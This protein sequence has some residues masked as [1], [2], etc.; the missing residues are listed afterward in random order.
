MISKATTP[1]ETPTATPGP[2]RRDSINAL[3]SASGIQ[4]RESSTPVSHQSI[5]LPLISKYFIADLAQSTPRRPYGPRVNST[6]I[7]SS[8]P[9][10][11]HDSISADR[12]ASYAHPGVSSAAN[13]VSSYQDDPEGFAGLEMGVEAD[14][15]LHDPEKGDRVSSVMPSLSFRPHGIQS[16]P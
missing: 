7:S 10:L 11:S 5:Q 4:S 2:S 14:D 15:D 8:Q 16:E 1:N 9:F 6:P 13:R 12:R 3:A